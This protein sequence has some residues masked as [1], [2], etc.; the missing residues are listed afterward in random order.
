MS[1]KAFGRAQGPFDFAQGERHGGN[2]QFFSKLRF[3]MIAT[4]DFKRGSTKILFKKEPWLVLSFSHVKPGK[5]GAFVK[6]KLR[7]LVSG[8]IYEETFRSGE[9]FPEPD[10]EYSTMQFLYADDQYHFM[11][12]E[13]YE[14]VAFNKNQLASVINYLKEGAC[15][16]MLAFEGKTLTM[17]AP[18][19]M[20][21]KVTETMPGVRGDTAQGGS[22][23][24]TLESGLVL[25]VPLFV[26]EGDV[27]KVDTREDLYIERVEK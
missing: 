3:D 8:V 5:G 7:S 9:K 19:F 20:D 6:T 12:Q 11:N 24:A 14:Q 13:N 23:P 27:L 25:Q 10:L 17:E 15:Y 21:L 4:S 2:W 18:M 1:I 16:N 26:A 22:K